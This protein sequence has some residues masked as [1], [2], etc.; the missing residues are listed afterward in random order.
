[1]CLLSN[2]IAV[3]FLRVLAAGSDLGGETRTQWVWVLFCH[4]NNLSGT[5]LNSVKPAHDFTH[6][7]P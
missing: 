2:Y 7:H 1:M 5:G 4:S 6:C 3:V